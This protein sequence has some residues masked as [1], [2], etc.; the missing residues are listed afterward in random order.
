MFKGPDA[1]ETFLGHIESGS[2]PT[3]GSDGRSLELENVEPWE[4]PVH[5][6]GLLDWIHGLIK[7]YL[8]VP[9]ETTDTLALWVLHTYAY[10]LR[11]VTTYIGVVSPERQCG[12]TTLL[13]LL[14][15]LANRALLAAKCGICGKGT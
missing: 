15:L 7:K 9:P 14:A 8:V 13:T 5:G 2:G 6:A 1:T 12:K 10:R 3:H 11:R 4:T